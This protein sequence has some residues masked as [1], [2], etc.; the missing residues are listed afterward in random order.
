MLQNKKTE[1]ITGKNV[2]RL[3]IDDI[4]SQVNHDG[5]TFEGMPRMIFEDEVP[6]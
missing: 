6:G 3:K 1:T 2:D 4:V 5:I